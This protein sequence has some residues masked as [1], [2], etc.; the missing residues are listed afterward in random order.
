MAPTG[1]EGGGGGEGHHDRPASASAAAVSHGSTCLL[2]RRT[3]A[4]KESA[5]RPPLAGESRNTFREPEL[6]IQPGNALVTLPLRSALLSLPAVEDIVQLPMT[7]FDSN[8]SSIQLP[9]PSV[10]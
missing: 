8:G 3:R 10:Y 5:G 7:S 9:L 2:D 6:G 4:E 1:E